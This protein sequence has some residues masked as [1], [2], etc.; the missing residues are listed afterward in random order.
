LLEITP[1][2]SRVCG[3][4]AATAAGVPQ[5]DRNAAKQRRRE[6]L[7]A[8]CSGPTVPALREL[9]ERLENEAGLKATAGTVGLDLKAIGVANPRSKAVRARRKARRTGSQRKLF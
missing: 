8:W 6:L 1:D 3:W 2:E 4:P 7:R 5:L 9:V